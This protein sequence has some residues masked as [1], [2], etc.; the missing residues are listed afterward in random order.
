MYQ[1]D[2][3]LL[4]ICLYVHK[5][6]GR[7]KYAPNYACSSRSKMR[8]PDI[9]VLLL[10]IAP[11]TASR[12]GVKRSSQSSDCSSVPLTISALRPSGLI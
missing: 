6:M 11:P 8:D 2:P 3:F 4:L 9:Q 7:G 12:T 10:S 1:C 5:K